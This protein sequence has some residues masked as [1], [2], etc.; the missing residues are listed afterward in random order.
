MKLKQAQKVIGTQNVYLN[1]IATSDFLRKN[2]MK[3]P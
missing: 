1:I 3:I 2:L